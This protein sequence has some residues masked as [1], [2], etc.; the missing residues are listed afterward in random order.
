[1]SGV[2]DTAKAG[3]DEL[4][5]KAGAAANDV[6]AMAENA[7]AKAKGDGDGFF[8]KVKDVAEDLVEDIKKP[9]DRNN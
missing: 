7:E 8:D 9:F 4:E 5:D 3:V 1:M 6:T 2:E